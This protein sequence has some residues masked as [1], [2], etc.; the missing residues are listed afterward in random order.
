MSKNAKQPL[1][2]AGKIIERFGG[3]RPMAA[4]IDTPVTTVQGW[5][6]RDVIPGNRRDQIMNAA[7][8]NN[9]DL[10][11]LGRSTNIANQNE[12]NAPNKSAS[13]KANVEQEKKLPRPIE[14]PEEKKVSARSVPVASAPNNIEN[15][16]EA[17]SSRTTATSQ[18]DIFAAI[19]ANNRKTLARSAWI[20]CALI[21]LAGVVVFFLL[22]PAIQN[23]ENEQRSL[24][25]QQSQEL[26]ALKEEVTQRTSFIDNMVPEGIQADLQERMDGLQTQARNIQNTVAQLSEQASAI[27]SGF[28]GAEAGPISQRLEMLEEKMANF[29]IAGNFGDVVERIRALENSIPGQEKLKDSVQE[30]QAMVDNMGSGQNI[31]SDNLAA[32]QDSGSALSETLQGV[33]G[34][35]L[36]A[37][38]MLIA[39]SQLRDSLNRE[40][41][42]ENDLALLERLVNEDNVELRAAID[43]LSPH[44]DGGV[45]TASGLS[46]EFKGLTGDVLE[47]SLRGEDISFK[48]K[49]KARF[50]N[51]FKVEKDGELVGGTASQESISK[52]QKLLDEGNI[53]GAIAELKT[54]DGEAAQTV[55][56]F[57]QQAEV[58]LLAERVQQMLGENILSRIGQQIPGMGL[59]GEQS[60]IQKSSG[61]ERGF[62]GFIPE[63]EGVADLNMDEVKQNLENAIPSFGS[64]EVIRDEESGVSILPNQSGFKG[65]SGGQ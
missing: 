52:A 46:S 56:P 39:F 3:I 65:F 29:S 1:E 63:I 37:A 44:A 27:S 58:S 61:T 55:Q 45:L 28:M 54:L 34:N 14:K 48:E 9:I 4:K 60:A 20:A 16:A 30:L 38:A 19:E 15:N 10:S 47:A 23:K 50:N 36:K 21:L 25:E 2:N 31:L 17:S 41:P 40:V 42:F 18:D 59:N 26:E 53:Q 57:L 49:A 22:S 11:D 51:I 33:S 13:Q 64:P 12:T 7:A 62:S 35:D 24:I 32:A 5:K 43:R 8:D 6:K